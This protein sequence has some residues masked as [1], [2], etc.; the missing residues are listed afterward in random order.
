MC[1]SEFPEDTQN[2]NNG[3][4]QFVM[5]V[6]ITQMALFFKTNLFKKPVQTLSTAFGVM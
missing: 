3:P 6:S 4:I 5:L 1:C 2:K